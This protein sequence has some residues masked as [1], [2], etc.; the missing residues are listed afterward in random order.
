MVL[1]VAASSAATTS[2][3]LRRAPDRMPS[4]RYCVYS[5]PFSKRMAECPSPSGR[6]HSRL[7]PL[8][9]QA[10]ARPVDGTMK[11]RVGPPHWVHAVGALCANSVDDAVTSAVTKAKRHN[12]VVIPMLD[13]REREKVLPQRHRGAENTLRIPAPLSSTGIPK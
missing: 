1:P 9:G 6:V 7:G 2:S 12:D 4:G 13:T 11:S 8:L 3:W 5:L 10:L